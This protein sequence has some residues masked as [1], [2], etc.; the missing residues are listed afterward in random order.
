[1]PC[2]YSAHLAVLG[3]RS[4]NPKHDGGLTGL[5]CLNTHGALI[6]GRL[7]SRL[8]SIRPVPV[9]RNPHVLRA[10][11]TKYDGRSTAKLQ[12]LRSE[13]VKVSPWRAFKGLVSDYATAEGRM[14]VS[15]RQLGLERKGKI[16]YGVVGEVYRASMESTE[17]ENGGKMDVAV[18]TLTLEAGKSNLRHQ[19]VKIQ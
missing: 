11:Q 17:I 9:P 14:M 5:T 15:M 8:A 4:T 7:T 1:M 13:P 10:N 6:T 18:K 12:E 2:T 16:G 19:L 3:P